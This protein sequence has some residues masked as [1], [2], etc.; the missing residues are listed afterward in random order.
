L[1]RHFFR[2]VFR[3]AG[4][5]IFLCSALAHAATLSA[6]LDHESAIG[7]STGFL[8]EPQGRLDLAQA[9]AAYRAGQFAPGTSPVLNFGIGSKPVWIHFAVDN[10]TAAPLH[11]WLSIENAWLDRVE[12]YFWHQGRI[13]TY[14][15]GDR[16]TFRQRP[17]VSR[18]FVFDQA[19]ESGVSDVFIRVETADPMVV[20]ITPAGSGSIPYPAKRS[21]S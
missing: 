13:T 11:R 6:T 9:V 17:V 21:R 7:L 1:H 2:L 10:P 14:R 3:L 5:L 8:Q 15:V 19:F 4:A 20:P 12:V 16:Q 18:Y